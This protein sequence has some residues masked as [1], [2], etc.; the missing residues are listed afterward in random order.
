MPRKILTFPRIREVR[1][2]FGHYDRH[3]DSPVGI[4]H[5]Q[6]EESPVQDMF[7]NIPV[8]HYPRAEFKCVSNM[9]SSGRVGVTVSPGERIGLSKLP[10]P[11]FRHDRGSGDSGG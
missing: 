3:V 6:L 8:A 7:L 11:V 4:V 5:A 10:I 9:A 1:Y 2:C